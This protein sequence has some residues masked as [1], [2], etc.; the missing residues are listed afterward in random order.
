VVVLPPPGPTGVRIAGDR[1]QWLVAWQGC[2]TALRDDQRQVSNPVIAVGVEVDEAGNLDD[3]VLY[4]RTP[5]HT[6]GQV[7]YAV[8]ATTPVSETYL[9][10]PSKAGGPSILRK[11]ADAW[12]RLTVD[13]QPADLALISNRTADPGDPL[14]SLRDA[15]TG[16]LLPRADVGGPRSAVGKARARWGEAAGLDDAELRELLALLRF[17]TGRDPQ[18]LHELTSLQMLAAGLRDDDQALDSGIDWIARQV[19]DGHQV[20]ELATIVNA[21]GNLGLTAAGPARAVLSVATLKPDPLATDAD[22][23]LDWVD[24]FEG[25]S[26]FSKRRPLPPATW[27]QLQ[28]DIAAIPAGLP[29]GTTAVALTGSLRQATAFAVGAALRQVTGVTDLAVKQRGQLWSS[30]ASYEHAAIPEVIEHRLDQGDILAVALAVAVDPTDEVLEFL[31]AAPVPAER[32]LV[33]RPPV[34]TRDNAIPDPASALALVVGIRD[35]VRQASRRNSEV[36]LFLAGPLGIA[37]L[38]GHRWNR[39]RPTV[40]YEDVRGPDTYEAAFTIDA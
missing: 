12:R 5:P 11:I 24:R 4:R 30:D 39:I 1:Y 14:V 40:V 35:L 22:Y 16:L 36:H 31:H 17:D 7:K 25:A 37:A 18:H 27:P 6:Y 21:V 3:C 13:G 20:L 15:R 34:G 23:A 9:L 29:P 2:I 33:L 28:R 8:D 32:L 19:R 38:L 10:E 26:D